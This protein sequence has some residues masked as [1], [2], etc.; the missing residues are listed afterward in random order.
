MLLSCMCY[1]CL[2]LTFCNSM[3]MDRHMYAVPILCVW[4]KHLSSAALAYRQK[5]H[6]PRAPRFRGPAHLRN[7]FLCARVNCGIA[8]WIVFTTAILHWHNILQHIRGN[9]RAPVEY[10]PMLLMGSTQG[11]LLSDCYQCYDCIKEPVWGNLGQ[12]PL[13]YKSWSHQA[14]LNHA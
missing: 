4:N 5:W 3:F 6:M 9:I 14:R 8:S 11:K 2:V 12:Y 13:L 1:Y 10:T 7:K